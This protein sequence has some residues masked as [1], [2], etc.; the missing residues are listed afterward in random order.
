MFAIG[1]CCSTPHNLPKYSYNAI[2]SAEYLADHIENL[3]KGKQSKPFLDKNV[4]FT[5]MINMS[6][7]MI[8]VTKKGAKETGSFMK[9]YIRGV[10]MGEM[11]DKCFSKMLSSLNKGMMKLMF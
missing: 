5:I 4:P 7:T 6:K 11:Q 9:G 3:H 10:S 1:D 8:Q 2:K